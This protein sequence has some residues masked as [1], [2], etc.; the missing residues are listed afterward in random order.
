MIEGAG[1]DSADVQRRIMATL[2]YR[3]YRKERDKRC[4]YQRK[5]SHIT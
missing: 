4:L 1:L 2:D 3:L 5:V